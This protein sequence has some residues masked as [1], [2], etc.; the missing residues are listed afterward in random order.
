M[1][2]SKWMT[3]L[4]V[5]DLGKDDL[6]CLAPNDGLQDDGET[7]M[8]VPTVAVARPPW[9]RGCFLVCVCVCL[10]IVFAPQHRPQ[11]RT[12]HIATCYVNGQGDDPEIWATS[13]R[14]VKGTAT[15]SLNVVNVC[16]GWKYRGFMTKFHAMA[17]YLSTIAHDAPNDLIVFTDGSDVV[18]NGRGLTTHDFEQRFDNSRGS[19]PILFLAEPFCWM[20]WD[21]SQRDVAHWYPEVAG[22][23][24]KPSR[25]DYFLN[26]G[27]IAGSAQSLLE[28]YSVAIS[29]SKNVTM[30]SADNDLAKVKNDDQGLAAYV[31]KLYPSWVALD[32]RGFLFSSFCN[33]NMC[34]EG[35]KCDH[36]MCGGGPCT[37]NKTARSFF[38]VGA[39]GIIR[40]NSAESHVASYMRE[41]AKDVRPLVL[42]GNGPCKPSYRAIVK[43]LGDRQP[44]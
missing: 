16:K 39:D 3:E 25:C 38:R 22:L 27:G 14:A 18:I 42:H 2:Q 23:R 41:C 33:G 24:P 32:Y 4:P 30:Q 9:S 40:R 35:D 7:S 13:A 43:E 28:F 20:G 31:R 6:D 21:C 36:M 26:S 19:A 1:S 17:E 29:F 12:F 11:H 44:V 8:S 34:P 5:K 10:Y 37:K 15:L